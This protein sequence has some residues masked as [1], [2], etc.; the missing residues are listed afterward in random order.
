MERNVLAG[1][2]LQTL[3]NVHDLLLVLAQLPEACRRTQ[4]FAD[5]G[6]GLE[7]YTKP[8]SE[9]FLARDL[10][11]DGSGRERPEAAR[12]CAADHMVVD[13]TYN[14]EQATVELLFVLGASPFSL[15]SGGGG[16]CSL[17]RT[18]ATEAEMGRSVSTRAIFTAA[19]WQRPG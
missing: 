9:I 10:V 6:V 15:Q 11:V 7:A 5:D 4:A 19:V 18:L 14:P 2:I 12:Y 13:I 8:E 3:D 16:D 1:G 17:D